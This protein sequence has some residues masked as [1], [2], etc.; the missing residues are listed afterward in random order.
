MPVLEKWKLRA[1]FFVMTDYADGKHEYMEHSH[2]R[3][4]SDKGMEVAAHGLDMHQSL[5]NLYIQDRNAWRRNIVGIKKRLEEIIE[6]EVV[7][8]AYPNGRYNQNTIDLVSEAGYKTAVRTGGN[9][10]LL[11]SSAIFEIPRVSGKL[12]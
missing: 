10:P 2:L 3:E 12:V 1:T 11:S 6:R 9:Y 5:P 8:F 4:I 7:S